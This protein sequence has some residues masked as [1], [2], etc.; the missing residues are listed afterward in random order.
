LGW[1]QREPFFEPGVGEETDWSEEPE[2]PD[3]FQWGDWHYLIFSVQGYTRYRISRNAFGPWI[4]PKVD[5]IDGPQLRVMKTAPF[6]GGRRL[7]AGFVP[8][9]GYG[10]H[11][12][13][14]ELVQHKD[15]SLG[16]K[17]APELVPPGDAR[18]RMKITPRTQLSRYGICLHVSQ[19]PS[20]AYSITF[21]PLTESVT[22]TLPGDSSVREFSLA[23]VAGLDKP[24]DL[25]VILLGELLDISIDQRRTF[26]VRADGAVQKDRSFVLT[27]TGDIDVQPIEA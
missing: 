5:A 24:I 17:F 9:A 21:D 7:A 19:T 11:I 12:V 26:V 14:R 25:E 10:G 16:T 4:R 15:G 3:Y 8:V 18:I 22:W 27:T 13:I 1:E 20:V 6:T 23:S 2:C